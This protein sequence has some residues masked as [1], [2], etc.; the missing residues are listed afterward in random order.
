MT[1]EINYSYDGGLYAELIRNRSF[2][3]NGRGQPFHWFVYQTGNADAS[4]AMDTSTGPSTA[5]PLSV[6]VTI[7]NAT[8]KDQ[9]GIANEGFW[10]MKIDPHTTYRGFVY[11]KTESTGIGPIRVA[12]VNSTTGHTLAS[13]TIPDIAS[14]WKQ[15][16]LTLTSGAEVSSTDNRLVFSVTRPGKLWLGLASLFPP[17]YH[18]RKNGNRPDLMEKLAAMKPGFLRFPGGDYLEGVRIADRFDWKKT[19]GPLID[20]PTHRSPWGYVS[21]DGLGLLEFLEWCED[22]NMEPV[23]GLYA[24]YSRQEHVQST[25]ELEPFVADALDEIEY[26]TGDVHTRWGAQRARD[27]HPAPFKLTCVEV[28]NEDYHDRSGSYNARFP[29]FFHAIR[30]KYPQLKIIATTPVKGTTIPDIIDDHY[31]RTASQFFDDADH[32]GNADRKGPKI[33]VGEWATIE[34]RPTPNFDAALGDAAW[35]TGME[36]N[37]DLIL[38]SC[39]APLFVNVNPGGMQWEPNLIGYDASSS[40]GS[41]SYYAQVMFSNHLG[42]EL[43][44]SHLDNAPVRFFY[45]VTRSHDSGTI[46]LKLV[47]ASD[48]PRQIDLKIDGAASLNKMGKQISLSAHDLLQTN[49]LSDPRHI[50]PVEAPLSN[51]ANHFSHIV[52]PFTIQVLELH[53]VK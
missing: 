32:Y 7:R 29:P 48:Q 5:L 22:L 43:L 53:S 38:M 36:R 46:F 15:Y 23:L 42:D 13:T 41:P 33:F 1:E 25:K 16:P 37:A 30:E 45:S 17:T 2:R 35:M 9:A 20:R 10:G 14:D 18:D 34:A 8:A 11:V 24:G 31:Y 50:V 40:Y 21:S 26:I 4:M 44:D 39:Y 19:I 49:T 6:A 12:L 3:D 52:P 51:V 27:G 47:N 28:G